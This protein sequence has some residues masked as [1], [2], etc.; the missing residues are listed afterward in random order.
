MGNNRWLKNSFVYPLIIIGVIVI[1][2][3][4]L[5]SFGGRVE[6]PLTTVIAMAKNHELREIVVDGRKLTVYPLVSTS[7][8]GDR[9]TSRIGNETD[10]ITLLV[11]SGVEVGPPAGVEVVFK[12]SSGFSSLFGLLI[13][14]LPIIT[15]GGLM[16]I[17]P[18]T[19]QKTGD[20]P[21]DARIGEW[22]RDTKDVLLERDDV[23]LYFF[24]DRLTSDLSPFRAFSIGDLVLIGGAMVLLLDLLLPRPFRSAD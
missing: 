14:F 23:H 9:F 2:Y 10:V 20:V 22:V 21:E 15:N 18:E 4:L 13:N 11:E 3:T 16:P 24:S 19:L 5:P 12:G 17:T 7:A 1:F 6:Q 8:T